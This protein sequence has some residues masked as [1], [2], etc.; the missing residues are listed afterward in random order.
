MT[1]K[2]R[3]VPFVFDLKAW[4]EALKTVDAEWHEELCEIAGINRVTLRNWLSGNYE[5]RDFKHP[6]MS[7]FLNVCNWLDIDPRDMFKLEEK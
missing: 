3:I 6:S 4:S 7:N 2:Y 5:K 1:T